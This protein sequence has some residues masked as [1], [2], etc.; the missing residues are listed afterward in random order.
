MLMTWHT[1]T[2]AE[3][4]GRRVVLGAICLPRTQNSGGPEFASVE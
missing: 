1:L 4:L 3:S 2:A